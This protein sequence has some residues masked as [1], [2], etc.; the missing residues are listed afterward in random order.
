MA[1]AFIT[2]A[3]KAR[4]P[5]RFSISGRTTRRQPNMRTGKREDE[6]ELR[7]PHGGVALELEVLLLAELIEHAKRIDLRHG[8]EHGL[9]VDEV[10]NL[11]LRDSGDARDR[12]RDPGPRQVEPRL[13]DGRLE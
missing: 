7:V 9:S 5:G 10:A 2:T 11:L 4:K 12:G 13:G 8:R 3:S 6:L 1:S